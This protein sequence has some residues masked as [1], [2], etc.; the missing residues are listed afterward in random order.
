MRVMETTPLLLCILTFVQSMEYCHESLKQ[1][2]KKIG[3]RWDDEEV[4]Q[5]C[6]CKFG[7]KVECQELICMQCEDGEVPFQVDNEDCCP[8][9]LTDWLLPKDGK[10]QFHAKVGGTVTMAVIT[11][12]PASIGLQK[13][14]FEWQRRRNSGRASIRISGDGK[15]LVLSE[16]DPSF[17]TD[18]RVT[19]CLNNDLCRTVTFS[20]NIVN[21]DVLTPVV[22]HLVVNEGEN[23]T[24]GVIV[25]MYPPIAWENLT[26]YFEKAAL[27]PPKNK[28]I[29]ASFEHRNLTIKNVTKASEGNYRCTF[30]D[31][32]GTRH[33]ANFT[34]KVEEVKYCDK[35]LKQEWKNIGERWDDEEK[36]QSCECKFGGKVECQELI[37][38][39]CEDGEVPFQV[40]NED[41]CP[42][43]LT[44]WLLPKDGKT[45]FHA[46][47]GGTVTMAVIT[48]LPASV[49]LQKSD[50]R[51]QRLRNSGRA[52]IR[53]S[54]DGKELVL[55]ELDP[56]FETD[57][58]VTLCLNND[59][60]RTVTFSL[61]IVNQDI[62]TPVVE[63]L[64]VNEGENVTFGVIV[65][66]YPPIAWEN[67]TW[68]FEKAAL[69]PPKNKLIEASFEHHNLTIKNVTKASEGNYR[70]TFT[71]RDGTRH[72]A[73]F[74]L[75][76]E[77]VKYCDKSLKQEW[78]NIGERWDDEEKCQSCEC[79]FG[80][81]VEC[82]ELICMQCE[83]G[84]VPFQVDN[85]DCC[86]A[87]LTDWLLPKDGKTQFHAKVGGTVTMAVITNLPAN[88]GLQ[89]SDFRWQRRRNSGR[90]SIRISGDGKE[91]V[92]SELDPS[93]ETD[94]RVT[95]CLNNDLCRTV[96]FSLNIVNQDVLTPVVEHVVVNE[97]ENVLFGVIV[98]MY[99]PIAWE[100]LT[101]YFEKA[102]LI[103][104]KNKLIEASFEHRNLTIKNATKAS[105]GNYRCTFTDR[106]GTRHS[107]NFTLKVEEVK[108]CD[109]S[110]KQEWKNIGERWDDEEVC[111]SCECKFGGKVECQ[112]L[113]CMQC[114][115]GEVPFQVENEDCCP[116]CL[117]DWLL[118]KDGK[119][120][121]HAKVGGTITLTVITNL[122]AGVG[123]QKSDFR[124][125]RLRNSGRAGYRIS[126]DGK[127]LVISVLDP[128]FE[129][130][131]RVTLC[132]NNDLCRTVTF[133]LNIVNQD[134]LTPVVEHLVVEEGENVTF[135]VIVDMYPP[136]AW[137]NLTWYFEEAALLLPKNKLIEASFERR[138]LTI[139]NV[140]KASEGNY[141]CTFTDR[142]G[143]LHSANFTLKVEEGENGLERVRPGT[144]VEGASDRLENFAGRHEVKDMAFWVTTIF[145][146][147]RLIDFICNGAAR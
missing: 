83:D 99:P 48:N 81:K 72:S 103:P 127:E 86:P 18:Y 43:C 46:K 106:D 4:C 141:R 31:R 30:T 26:W 29:E 112:E 140:A 62:L 67:L 90:A 118:P 34:L 38:M 41:C 2:W 132:L 101:W 63:H 50:F 70:C 109:K 76:V 74:T 94:Y 75:K 87:C 47:V 136:I 93:F 113:I 137:E 91:L 124:W 6:E 25:D 102:A 58:R 60:C 56:S 145:I 122:P 1:E 143:T 104:P 123:L 128:G 110:L 68:Y 5:S 129:T 53:I 115:D 54:G 95:L 105:E 78:K 45:Q 57:Y 24:F 37:C 119:T 117:T 11:N 52:S 17:E 23:V 146:M 71:D 120:Q 20:L 84:E 36:C 73:N 59:L 19:L 107:A 131:Y 15:E 80:G 125:Q 144:D 138:N 44:D 92:L 21:Q 9:C 134:V 8:A 116:A 28:L 64:V 142:D 33:S 126:G 69:I 14:D 10:T 16:L 85:E 12:L 82:Q 49:G 55:S 42:V 147:G 3:E 133:S 66:M 88:V 77:E 111:Q 139:K 51:W 7:G 108:Y 130:D 100:N 89:K 13:S 65:D 79:K 96:T 61:N 40:Y 135:G 114:E 121:F 35:S 97:G 22:E 32:D 98:D 27:I 39:Q